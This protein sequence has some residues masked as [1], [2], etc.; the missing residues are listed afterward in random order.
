[1]EEEEGLKHL[2]HS[3]PWLLVLLQTWMADRAPLVLPKDHKRRYLDREEDLANQR[4]APNAAA[5]VADRETAFHGLHAKWRREL[6]AEVIAD[7]AAYRAA[8]DLRAR[9]AYYAAMRNHCEVENTAMPMPPEVDEVDSLIEMLGEG[10]GPRYRDYVETL[11]TLVD[12]HGA[13]YRADHG[14]L[15]L[16]PLLPHLRDSDLARLA[17]AIRHDAADEG[18]REVFYR[19]FEKALVAWVDVDDGACVARVVRAFEA[20]CVGRAPP[21]SKFEYW[22][23]AS[24]AMGMLS[25]VV[26]AEI[27]CAWL[28]TPSRESFLPLP[29]GVNV[30]RIVTGLSDLY[31]PT[32]TAKFFSR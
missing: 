7:R 25:N 13:V 19:A 21:R 26:K 14:V 28:A 3:K 1:M 22:P 17:R 32:T 2:V 15:A 20:L 6:H 29:F 24:L 12:E 30:S 27:P 4:S 16:A 11:L 31:S 23:G 9:E 5:V 18:C 8:L 10:G